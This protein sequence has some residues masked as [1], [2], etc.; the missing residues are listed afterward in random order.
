MYRF[1]G[2]DAYVCTAVQ[3]TDPVFFFDLSDMDNITYKETGT[4]EG[5]STSL[6]N[7]GNGYLLGIGTGNVWGSLKIEIYEESAT[8]VV[9]VCW[10]DQTS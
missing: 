5:F 2:T 8:G 10:L 7:F 4:I 1:D 6:V 3:L 9:S